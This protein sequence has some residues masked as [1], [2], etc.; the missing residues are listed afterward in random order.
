V[1]HLAVVDTNVL[2]SGMATSDGTAPTRQ[3]VK[4][5]IGGTLRLLLSESLL[6]EYR[7]VLLRAHIARR[8][9]LTEESVDRLLLE[10]VLNAV[11]RNPVVEIE[12]GTEAHGDEHIVALLKTMPGSVLVTG[13]RRLADMVAAWCEVATPAAFA[14]T[15][16]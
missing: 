15:L 7:R 10:I 6:A 14:A 5:M 13:D 16:A 4:A 2:V 11:I 1:I 8:H 9:G 3:I 12:A